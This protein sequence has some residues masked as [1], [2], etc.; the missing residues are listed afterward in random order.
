MSEPEISDDCGEKGK[1]VINDAIY[2]LKYTELSVKEIAYKL[3]FPNNSIF[4]K[5]FRSHTGMSP[6]VCRKSYQPLLKESM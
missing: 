5:Y 2:M 4:C 1:F 6:M 3:N